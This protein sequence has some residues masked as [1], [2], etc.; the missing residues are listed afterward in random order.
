M[1]IDRRL[2]PI[3][4]CPSTNRHCGHVDPRTGSIL[5]CVECVMRERYAHEE[6]AAGRRLIA[7]IIVDRGHDGRLLVTQEQMEALDPRTVLE[8]ESDG[9]GGIWLRVTTPK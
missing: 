9:A 8:H 6:I 1:E 2:G 4:A 3:R 7:A 5:M